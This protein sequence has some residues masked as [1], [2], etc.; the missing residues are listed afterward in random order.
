MHYAAHASHPDAQF[1][2]SLAYIS[3]FIAVV[4]VYLLVG[5]GYQRLIAGA[6]GWEQI[7]NYAFWKDFGNLTAVSHRLIQYLPQLVKSG[8]H[9]CIYFNTIFILVSALCSYTITERNEGLSF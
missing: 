7:P 6:K 3:R 9:T 4:G 8:M 1:K 5:C 2:I